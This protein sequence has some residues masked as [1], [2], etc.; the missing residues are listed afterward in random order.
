VKQLN[1][2]QIDVLFR[3]HRVW[4]ATM[5]ESIAQAR[6][7]RART[8]LHLVGGFHTEFDGGLIQELRAR[9]PAARILVIS[10]SPRR[11]DR[12]A[13]G[14]LGKADFLIYTRSQSSSDARTQ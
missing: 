2:E 1:D 4:D 10:L 3:A 14:D 13:S 7:G 8:V 5:A 12:F 9:D 11:S 6:A